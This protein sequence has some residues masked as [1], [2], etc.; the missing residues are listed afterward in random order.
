MSIVYIH[1]MKPVT[2]SRKNNTQDPVV[3]KA[4]T[5]LDSHAAE[6]EDAIRL[7]RRNLPAPPG[8]YLYFV[9]G[10]VSVAMRSNKLKLNYKIEY[11][12]YVKD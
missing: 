10:S 7:I 3:A 11:E 1:S 2:Q 6:L 4:A 8:K 5:E 12:K 9:L